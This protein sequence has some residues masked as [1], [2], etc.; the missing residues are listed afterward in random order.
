MP[1]AVLEGNVLS[2]SKTCD[3]FVAGLTLLGVQVAKT[4]EAVRAVVSGGEVLTGQLRLT[5]GAHETLFMPRL[6]PIGHSTFSQGLFTAG[7]ARGKLVLVAGN[8][9]M[10][11]LVGDEGLGANGLFAAV[12][13]KTALVPCGAAVLQLPRAWHDDLVTGDTFRGELVAVAVVAEQSIILT[14]EGLISQ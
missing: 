2:S 6:V 8:A 9:V 4:L 14:R 13:D 11:V 10:F 7:A 1:L 12:T 5:V 3:G